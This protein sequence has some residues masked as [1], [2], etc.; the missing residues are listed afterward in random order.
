MRWHSGAMGNFVALQFQAPEL[1]LL[2][3]FYCLGFHSSLKNKPVGGL[4]T[5]N[6]C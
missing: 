3:M 1:W 5:L 6:C 2:C 4:V